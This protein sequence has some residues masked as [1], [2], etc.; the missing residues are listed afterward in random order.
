[1]PNGT[2]VEI[3]EVLDGWYKVSYKG[4]TGYVSSKYVKVVEE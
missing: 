3:I 2:K 1:L 4:H